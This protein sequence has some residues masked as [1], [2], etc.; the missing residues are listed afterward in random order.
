MMVDAGFPVED[1]VMKPTTGFV[2]SFPIEAPKDSVFRDDLDVIQQLELWK[3]YQEHY[4][5]HKP[6]VTVYVKEDEWIRCG[7]W[8][9]DNFDVLSGISFLP[10]SGGSYKQAPYQEINEEEYHA[11][12]AAMPRDV[13]WS[14]LGNYEQEDNTETMQTLACSGTSCELP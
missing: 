7:N 3:L 9:Y 14:L 1:D 13:N 8:V 10:H 5:E 4:T 11:A 2:F 6:S 12:V